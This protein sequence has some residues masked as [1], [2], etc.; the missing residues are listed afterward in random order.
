MLLY[1]GT[2]IIRLHKQKNR[3]N[4]HTIDEKVENIVLFD[5]KKP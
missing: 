1:Y 3:L 5:A 4:Y 2:I